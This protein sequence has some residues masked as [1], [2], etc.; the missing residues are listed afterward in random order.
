M[1][2]RVLAGLTVLLL[3]VMMFTLPI[4]Y[5][6]ILFLLL[7]VICCYE[8]MH[9]LEISGYAPMKK[10]AYVWTVL[11][12]VMLYNFKHGILWSRNALGGQ[13]FLLTLA[14]LCM[15]LLIGTVF[16]RGRK[17]DF[18]S[19][20]YT[21]AGCIYSVVLFGFAVGIIEMDLGKWLLGYVVLGA[22]ATDT[23]AYFVGYFLG[24]RKILPDISP[25]KTVEGSIGGYIGCAMIIV[26]YSFIMKSITGV[27]PATW[28][29]VVIALT[30]G[31]YAQIGDWCASFIKRHFKIKD[32]GK[33]IPGHGGLLDRLDSIIF[34]A[35]LLY[36]IFIIG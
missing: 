8:F 24:K 36:L 34:L 23:F 22:V 35:P 7:A 4:T 3:A 31:I 1:K 2:T 33:L 17:H 15:A 12:V 16:S 27:M 32:F 25:K 29:I 20:A 21:L 9:M 13:D 18:K 28:K 19:F 11:Y 5:F 10:I 14:F 30:A 6:Y 26:G